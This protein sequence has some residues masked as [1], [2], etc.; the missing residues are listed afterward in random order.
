FVD[1][2]ACDL[3]QPQ[4]AVDHDRR[5][6]GG[7]HSRQAAAG[8]LQPGALD[9]PP[10]GGERPVGAPLFGA[11]SMWMPRSH[12]ARRAPSPC[13]RGEGGCRSVSSI[14]NIVPGSTPLPPAG[15]E[16]WAEGHA[17]LAL[18]SSLVDGVPIF[19]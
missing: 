13:K 5:E 19:Y 10:R 17:H 11:N 15:G 1:L 12:P 9:E 14:F 6:G 3:R 16:G 2:P 7:P 8:P 18:A 4:C